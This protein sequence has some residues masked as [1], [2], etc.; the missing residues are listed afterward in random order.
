VKRNGADIGT[1]LFN[2]TSVRAT[3]DVSGNKVFAAGDLLTITM[4]QSASPG[5]ENF[6]VTLRMLL[7]NNGG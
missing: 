3:F 2:P 6:S 5:F 4:P 7:Q 1:I